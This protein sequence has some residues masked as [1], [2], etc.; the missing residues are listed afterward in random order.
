MYCFVC[1][2]SPP[3]IF[4]CSKWMCYSLFL[5]FGGEMLIGLTFSLWLFAPPPFLEH[6]ALILSLDFLYKE[7]NFF[8][9]SPPPHSPEHK[10]ASVLSSFCQYLYI[11]ANIFMQYIS[12]SSWCANFYQFFANIMQTLDI[13]TNIFAQLS[14]SSD[15][16]LQYVSHC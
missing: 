7:V 3:P 10:W 8:H 5:E 1:A 12:T 14:I 15:A 13:S 4:V 16:A 9:L 6:T 2:P 11:F